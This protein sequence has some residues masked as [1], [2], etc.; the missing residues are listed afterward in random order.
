MA[1]AALRFAL[2]AGGGSAPMRAMASKTLGADGTEIW[3]CRGG[4]LRLWSPELGVLCCRA[5]GD[6]PEDLAFPFVASL[7]QMAVPGVRVVVFTDIASMVNYHTGFRV[8]VTQVLRQVRDRTDA[9]HVLL[10]STLAALGVQ[11]ANLVLRNFVLHDTRQTFD[12][13]LVK[14]VSERKKG[15]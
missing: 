15:R 7:Q 5:S 13:A 14:L 9:N 10:G 1:G 12:A 2:T 3:T 4:E 8:R 11:V 6:I